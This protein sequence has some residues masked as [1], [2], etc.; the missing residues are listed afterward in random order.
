MAVPHS[1]VKGKRLLIGISSPS[2]AIMGG[3]KHW[4]FVVEDSIY[5]AWCYFLKEKSELKDVMRSSL[6]DLKAIGVTGRYVWQQC[7]RK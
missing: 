7:W 1:M 2:T 4:L 5:H 6:K 3:N